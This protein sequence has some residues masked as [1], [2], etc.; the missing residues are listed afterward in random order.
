M[1]TVETYIQ[2]TLQAIESIRILVPTSS[3]YAFA[4]PVNAEKCF[5]RW[6]LSDEQK[7]SSTL[8]INNG[9]VYQA[10]VLISVFAN[11]IANARTIANAVEEA[12]NNDNI[13][14]SDNILSSRCQTLSPILEDKRTVHYPIKA[15]IFYLK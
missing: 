10:N 2:N 9:R 6:T 12:F 1:I 11:T 3:I 13:T 14:S 5:I 4:S 8:D 15:S 7:A